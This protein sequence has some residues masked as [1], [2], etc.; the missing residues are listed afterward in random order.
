MKKYVVEL[1]QHERESLRN[2]V[3][4]GKGPAR[5]FS[6]ARILLKADVSGGAPAWPDE[7]ISEAFDVTVQT[8]ERVR[9]QLVLE[10]FDAV[11]KRRAYTQKVSRKKVDGDV[12]AHLVALACSETPDGYSR[13][14]LRLLADQMVELG[15]IDSISHEAVR[16]TLKKTN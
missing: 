11:L 3:R 1:S 16:Q 13:W 15:Y 5:M 8:V 4:S 2:L 6:H 9:K 10:G 14:S 7:R 12:E